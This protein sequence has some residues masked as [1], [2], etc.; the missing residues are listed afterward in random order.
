MFSIREIDDQDEPAWDCFVESQAAASHYHLYRWRRLFRDFYSKRTYYFG[1]FVN[2][3]LVGVLPLAQQKSRL[4]GNYLVSLP[5]LNYG[6]V[7]T[8][9]PV[10]AD[11]LLAEL[12]PL[13]ERVGASHVELREFVSRG[14]MPCRTDKVTM[15]LELPDT[16]EQLGKSIGAK[17]RSQI[18]RPQRENPIVSTGG[19]ELLDSF[20][21]V[22]GRNMRD[23]GTPVYS[24][25]M[26][27]EILRLFPDD[28][29][30]IVVKIADR[31]VAA[32]FLI[33][34]RDTVEVPWA[35]ADRR[36]NK[37]SINMLLYWEILR[38]CIKAGAAVFDFGR[39]SPDS[40]TYRF[41]KQWGAEPRQLH[42]NYVLQ[43]RDEIPIINPSNP[44]YDFAISLWSRMPVA[45]S[46][47]LGPFLARNLP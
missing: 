28:C 24:K 17:R 45:I 10:V 21:T 2:D 37:I 19:A 39:S 32:A 29:T 20:Y 14:D 5:F 12:P 9:D 43:G 13:A 3:T 6:G 16:E 40:G 41:K 11:A 44:K 26:F 33:R 38:H 15:F 46:N 34:Y 8:E 27:A 25:S 7:L 47:R 4:F 42:W 35:S 30:I 1:A 31:P 36:Y 22:F 23:L 18:R